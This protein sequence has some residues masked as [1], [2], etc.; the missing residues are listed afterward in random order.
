MVTDDQNAELD[1]CQGECIVRPHRWRYG[2]NREHFSQVCQRSGC[3]VMGTGDPCGD[4]NCEGDLD[5]EEP[6]VPREALS[7][8]HFSVDDQIRD[9]V[10][11]MEREHPARY[12]ALLKEFPEWPSL[13]WA[14]SWV[15]ANA[16]EVDPDFMSWVADWI[17]SRSNVRV[18]WEDGEPWLYRVYIPEDE[19]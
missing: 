14:G 5:P 18:S 13:T 19:A 10:R 16:S 2:P 1:E 9:V 4:G 17:E 12:A 6:E 11:W 3:N 7:S 8:N 15:D